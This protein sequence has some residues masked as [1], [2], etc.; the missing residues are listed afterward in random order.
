MNDFG[1][2][3]TGYFGFVKV[4]SF[5]LPKNATNKQRA[6]KIESGPGTQPTPGTRRTIRGRWAEDNMPDT[7]SSYDF[8]WCT[9][10]SG[11]IVDRLPEPVDDT[12]PVK[13]TTEAAPGLPSKEELQA[14][15]RRKRG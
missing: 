12:V 7:I 5:S 8:A 11:E 6:F 15:V 2:D 10:T 4:R 14:K 1:V 13:L 9:K 3:I